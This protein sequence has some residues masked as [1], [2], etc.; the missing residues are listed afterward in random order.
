[1]QLHQQGFLMQG[2][3]GLSALTASLD[4]MLLK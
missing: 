2:L 4:R 1:M 3:Q